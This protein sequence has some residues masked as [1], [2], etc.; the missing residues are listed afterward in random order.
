V[1]IA[2]LAAW[3]LPALSKGKGQAQSIRCKS[4][5]HQMGVGPRLY[6]RD[7]EHRYPYWEVIA[8]SK[9]ARSWQQ[10]RQPYYAMRWT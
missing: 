4:N 9:V 3:L 1:D 5:L 2:I 8:N 10:S 6:L 7:S